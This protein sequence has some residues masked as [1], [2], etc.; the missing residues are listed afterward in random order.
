MIKSVYLT[1]MGIVLAGIARAQSD[2]IVVQARPAYN[3]VGGTHRIIFGENYRKEW[4]APAKL[5][6]IKISERGLTPTEPG[7]GKQTKS[8]R[9]KD[10][11]GKEWTIRSI[12]KYPVVLLPVPLRQTFVA[13]WLKDAMSSEH[14]YGALMVPVLAS[15]VQVPHATPVIGVIAPDSALG[16]YGN[17]FANTIC[18][19]EE[20]EP[21]GE[22]DNT[23]KMYKELDKDNDNKIDTLTLFRARLLDFFLG[24]WDRHADQWRWVDMKK[25]SGKEYV[26]VPRDRDQAFFYNHGIIPDI[27]SRKWLAPFLT[28]FDGRIRRGNTFFIWDGNLNARFFPQLTYDQWMFE[29]KKFT[30]LLTDSVLEAALARLPESAYRIRHDELLQK[31]KTRRHNMV[32]AMEDYYYFYNRLI[33][34]K[35][36]DKNELVE[37]TD[38]SNGKLQVTIHKISKDGAIKDQLFARTFDPE[39]TREI[40]IYIGNGKDSVVLNTRNRSIKTRIIGGEG[41]QV[42]NIMEAGRKVPLY[43]KKESAHFIGKTGRL[44]KHI[45]NDSINTAYVPAN[46]YNVTIP[47]ITAGFNIDDGILLGPGFRYVRRGFRKIPYASVQQASAAYSFSTSALRVKYR[48]EW[49][50]ALGRFTDITLQAAVFAPNNTMNF[51]GRGNETEYNRFNDRKTRIKIYRIRYNMYQVNPSIRWNL[52]SGVSI[53]A[54]PSLWYYT[55]SQDDNVGRFISN[56]G[57]IHSYDS[58]TVNENK[59]HGGIILHFINDKRNDAMLPT[60]GSWISLKV[61]GYKGLNDFSKSFVQII[62]E[63]ALY[64]NL[65]KP[66][67]VIIANRVGG[68]ITAGKT[69]FYQSAFLGGQENLLGYRQYRFAGDHSLYNNLELRVKLMNIAGYILPGQ[70]GLTGF[71]DIG[72]VWQKNESSKSWHQGAGGGLYFSPAQMVL[73]QLVAGYSNEGWYPYFTM[74]FRF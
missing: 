48:G 24:D 34:I 74:G 26:P 23:G 7:G 39:H 12:E 51:F 68:V 43:E 13:D 62:P 40:R 67:T 42:Y 57:Q 32:Q 37:L 9:L 1:L 35:T 46:R 64:K 18:L 54:G 31:M 65:N 16:R 58:L 56:T 14:P 33:E 71:Y 60:G 55:F 17:T 8:L 47:L 3:T 2:S 10:A 61:Q 38:A 44:R 73:F 4:A 25:G 5:P 52:D 63:F 27:A 21:L 15:A 66:A 72:R 6:V 29:T 20:R 50:Q 59:L 70:L 53:S 36:S 19:L 22:S 41:R 69:A 28:G 30:A 11:A 45:S 49:I